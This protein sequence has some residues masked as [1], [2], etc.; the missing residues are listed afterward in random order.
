M[1]NDTSSTLA[2]A[3]QRLH[4]SLDTLDKAVEQKLAHGAAQPATADADALVEEATRDYAERVSILE[5]ECDNFTQEN[6]ALR[7]ENIRL[8][9]QLQ[10]LQDEHIQL[11][12]VTDKATEKLDSTIKQL[13]LIAEG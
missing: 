1:T 9:N 8:S 12:Q 2:T 13:D 3:M 6:E 5:A 4:Q 7:E 10:Q 11:K